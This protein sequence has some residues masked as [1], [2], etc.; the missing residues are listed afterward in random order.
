MCRRDLLATY[1]VDLSTT[2]NVDLWAIDARVLPYKSADLA[3]GAGCFWALWPVWG[4]LGRRSA[5]LRAPAELSV[6][7]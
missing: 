3:R 7:V 2:M 6:F 4:F 1:M 5:V